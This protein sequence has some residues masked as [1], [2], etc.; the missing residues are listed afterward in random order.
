VN[1]ITKSAL[2][3]GVRFANLLK[4]G[5][6]AGAAVSGFDLA[7]A[8]AVGR[9]LANERAS[10]PRRPHLATINPVI[11]CSSIIWRMVSN[12]APARGQGRGLCHLNAWRELSKKMLNT[13][14]KPAGTASA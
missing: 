10:P 14:R 6:C 3:Q 1:A 5:L 9:Y 13:G 11:A 8:A 2:Q 7:P 12:P 4:Y